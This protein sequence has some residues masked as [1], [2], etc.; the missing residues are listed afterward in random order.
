[1]KPFLSSPP[2]PVASPLCS[3][4]SQAYP[5]CPPTDAS[6]LN[7]PWGAFRPALGS[8]RDE[9]TAA[10]PLTTFSFWCL[11]FLHFSHKTLPPC[12]GRVLA[13]LVGSWPPSK[14]PTPVGTSYCVLYCVSWML[15]ESLPREAEGGCPV[16]FSFCSV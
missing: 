12:L 6:S 13:T 10:L 14:L 15:T 11:Y 5:P 4:E 8:A 9:S 16:S 1:M 7:R 3:A 2:F